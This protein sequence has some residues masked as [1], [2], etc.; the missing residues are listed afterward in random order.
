MPTAASSRPGKLFSRRRT[1]W[2]FRY[3][4]FDPTDLV[5]R[6]ITREIRGA[7][8]YYYARHGLKWQTDIGPVE[9]SR[10]P[11]VTSPRP[12]NSGRSCSSFSDAAAD[13]LTSNMKRT[14][15]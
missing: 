5:D 4:Q 1:K 7:F 13:E 3:G 6:N 8:S 15:S 10:V 14:I 9:I 11:P 2:P 12:G